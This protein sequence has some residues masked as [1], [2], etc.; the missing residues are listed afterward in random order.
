[1]CGSCEGLPKRSDRKGV[2]V[3]GYSSAG[4]YEDSGLKEERE[5][6]FGEL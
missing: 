1:M 4:L 5:G 6:A 3:V 2:E